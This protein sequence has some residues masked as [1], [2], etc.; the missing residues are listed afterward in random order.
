[1]LPVPVRWVNIV[2]SPVSESVC[3]VMPPGATRK[4]EIG[5]DIVKSS[6]SPAAADRKFRISR[7]P[8]TRYETIFNF[9]KRLTHRQGIKCHEPAIV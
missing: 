7:D 8:W 1:M 6:L 2:P 5:S 3:L 9:E 4:V